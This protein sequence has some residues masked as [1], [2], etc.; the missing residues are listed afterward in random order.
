MSRTPK[1]ETFTVTA[2]LTKS[3]RLRE[4]EL[5]EEELRKE[6]IEPTLSG[7]EKRQLRRKRIVRFLRDVFGMVFLAA[8][9]A[10][11]L[12]YGYTDM[13]AESCMVNSCGSCCAGGMGILMLAAT[14]ACAEDVFR[15]PI[16]AAK[17]R[18]A[19]AK[20]NAAP[21][22]AETRTYVFG[23]NRLFIYGEDA[24]EQYPYDG[25][26]E[27]AGEVEHIYELSDGLFIQTSGHKTYWLPARFISRKEGERL[28]ERLRSLPALNGERPWM[29]L[30]SA[31]YPDK[32]EP[33]EPPFFAAC[34]GEGEE[35]SEETLLSPIPDP[36]CYDEVVTR[37][38]LYG[39]LLAVREFGDDEYF[40]LSK[41]KWIRRREREYAI[42]TGEKSGD[43]T[44]SLYIA[45]YLRDSL[46]DEEFFRSLAARA[47]VP[48]E[49]K[50]KKKE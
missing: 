3:D 31:K 21:D 1:N 9:A 38:A 10:M 30:R 35:P 43:Y 15:R 39:D 37:I 34:L 33:T 41:L 13:S 18:K 45:D 12:Y 6:Y 14:W 40:R 49:D 47:G 19:V 36:E 26:P 20:I 24:F 16:K 29:S 27:G 50:R 46:P 32:A 2:A 44:I 11:F 4:A 17:R 23:R 42:H 22:T 25:V 28:T 5:D 8:I 7:D 48:Y